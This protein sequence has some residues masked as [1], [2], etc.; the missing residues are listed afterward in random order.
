MARY[1]HL[2][3]VPAIPDLLSAIF[4]P[5][6]PRQGVPQCSKALT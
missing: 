1:P 5:L 4:Q 6:A 2:Q 3:R